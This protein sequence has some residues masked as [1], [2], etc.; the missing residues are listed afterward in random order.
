MSHVMQ[1][2]QTILRLECD[3]RFKAVKYSIG[4]F[5]GISIKKFLVIARCTPPCLGEHGLLVLRAK[6]NLWTDRSEGQYFIIILYQTNPLFKY[7]IRL[8]P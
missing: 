3:P 7:N 6:I 8:T 2:S 4:V 1:S 5:K